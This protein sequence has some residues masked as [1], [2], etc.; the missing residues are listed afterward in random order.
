MASL[1]ETLSTQSV[2]S[3]LRPSP[4]LDVFQGSRE[5]SNPS[6]SQLCSS[7][8]I[9]GLGLSQV[10]V[11]YRTGRFGAHKSVEIDRSKPK[12]VSR[13]GDGSVLRSAGRRT[14]FG[15]RAMDLL[16]SLN[17]GGRQKC[18]QANANVD[19]R[20]GKQVA[21]IAAATSALLTTGCVSLNAPPSSI[22][23]A[24]D[25]PLHT[26]SVGVPLLGFV[27]AANGR[28]SNTRQTLFEPSSRLLLNQTSSASDNGAWLF[29]PYDAVAAPP[30]SVAIDFT[31]FGVDSHLWKPQT[32]L[33]LEI[34]SVAALGLEPVAE[35]TDSHRVPVEVQ[36][37]IAAPVEALISPAVS[38]RILI[39][40]QDL[41]QSVMKATAVGF[42]AFVLLVPIGCSF[43]AGFVCS[44]PRAGP[45][46][47]RARRRSSDRFLVSLRQAIANV[48]A[49]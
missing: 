5:G 20:W 24:E 39:P 17:H 15:D 28:I 34:E 26:A 13:C 8:F 7:V 27:G 14:D 11:R 31:P 1:K 48:P 44:Q 10:R 23:L 6:Y 42:L 33:R 18:L 12:G 47:R 19:R 25:D 32:D 2:R 45:R 21:L 35:L 36:P 4:S 37:T 49:H 29:T 43:V 30:I 40:R 9:C 41:W 46:R 38:S 16:T 22:R 3:R